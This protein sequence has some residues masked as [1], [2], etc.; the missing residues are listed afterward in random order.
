MLL[1]HDT[2]QQTSTSGS[3]NTIGSVDIKRTMDHQLFRVVDGSQ[4]VFSDVQIAFHSW[5]DQD[6]KQLTQ[7]IYGCFPC[8][9]SSLL[10]LVSF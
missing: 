9:C 6:K 7:N 3:S 2:L 8:V 1:L 4:D 10:F 5:H